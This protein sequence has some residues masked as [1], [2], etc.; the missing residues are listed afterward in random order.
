MGHYLGITNVGYGDYERGNSSI[1]LSNL[2]KVAKLFRRPPEW[3][4]GEN[5]DRD[6]ADEEE[7]LAMY[8]NAT[9]DL[10]PIAKRTLKA[11]LLDAEREDTT[12][13]KKAE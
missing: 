9:P 2:L 4:I 5:V 1:P 7:F 12:F 3:F 6:L 8:R 10:K 13:G 11:I